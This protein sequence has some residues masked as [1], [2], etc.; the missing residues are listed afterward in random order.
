MKYKLKILMDVDDKSNTATMS[1]DGANSENEECH[2]IFTDSNTVKRLYNDIVCLVYKAGISGGTDVY[3]VK[4]NLNESEEKLKERAEEAIKSVDIRNGRFVVTRPLRECKCKSNDI[5][6]PS[7][8]TEG[9]Q[10]EPRKVIT[11]WGL[12]W[13]LGNTVK[14]ISRAGRKDDPVK[15]LKK[16]RQYLDWAIEDFECKGKE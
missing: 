4:N 2:Y 8:Y 3:E 14:Y 1:I 5:S 10:Y 13:N 9:R 6:N 16:A 12:D 15:D 7:H 11:D